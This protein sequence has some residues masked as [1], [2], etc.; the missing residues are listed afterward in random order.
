MPLCLP[1]FRV[2][3]YVQLIDCYCI[4]NCC[5]VPNK[6]VS[7]V[8]HCDIYIYILHNMD[9]LSYTLTGSVSIRN[10]SSLLVS[11]AEE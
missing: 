5:G 7:T 2:V 8:P 6:N 1:L 4:I 10:G 9:S 11:L 3:L